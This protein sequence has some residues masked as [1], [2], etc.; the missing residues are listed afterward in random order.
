MKLTELIRKLNQLY[1]VSA[2]FGLH[3]LVIMNTDTGEKFEIRDDVSQFNV[4]H[5]KIVLFVKP[6][7]AQGE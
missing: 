1:E 3:E 7:E 6:L 2:E 5:S 4:E